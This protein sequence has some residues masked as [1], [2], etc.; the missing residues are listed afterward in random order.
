MSATLFAIPGPGPVRSLPA[1]Y[2][3]PTQELEFT[4]VLRRKP[5]TPQ[6]AAPLD[7]LLGQLPHQRQYLTHAELADATGADA[8]DVATLEAYLQ[9]FGIQ[10][11]NTSL[12]LRQATL[13]GSVQAF[14]Q[15]FATEIAAFQAAGQPQVLALAS[16]LRVP[17]PLHELLYAV[18][19]LSPPVRKEWR[20]TPKPTP[21]P[22]HL[23]KG[24]GAE[25]EAAGSPTSYSVPE[26][27]QAYRFPAE[28]TGAG[29][30]VGIVELGGQFSHEDLAQYFA[31]LGRPQPEII[32]VGTSPNPGTAQLE[33]T[34]DVE[35]VGALLPQ[36][37]L[38]VYYA[39]T[40]AGAL[41][42]IVADE[43]N[44]P[45][46]VSI[47]WA[48][49]EYNYTAQEVQLLNDLCYQAA[50]LGITL[51]AASA[52]LG[53]F[54]GL[55]FPNVSLPSSNPL[56][57][58]CGGTTATLL[59]GALTQEVVW[60]EIFN[61]NPADRMSS[62]GGVSHLYPLPYYQG[63]AVPGYPYSLPQSG[64]RGVPDLAAHASGQPGYQLIYNGQP[65]L[66]GGTSAATPLVAALLALLNEQLGYRL[67]FVNAVLYALAGSAAFRP[68][69]QGNNSFYAAAPYW[70]PCTGLGSP[71]G[72][73]LLALLQQVERTGALAPLAPTPDD[74]A[75][76]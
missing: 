70:N 23:L 34:M 69:T 60:N 48:G 67:G 2:P 31:S 11:K 73:Q 22:P 14:E 39:H 51:V 44:K 19:P 45:T 54:N 20:P 49:S 40:L 9:P 59:N 68:I 32:E 66:S 27:A 10:I 61:N 46:V 13:A 71:V 36:A 38:V 55:A 25:A 42:A 7:A 65:A 74:Q 15:A 29:Q 35:I 41:Q 8:A 50:L 17:A 56:V 21:V 58:G 26:L 63:R 30:V 12:L 52:D 1:G 62:G 47:S 76:T 43:A 3:A 33:V 6:D 16:P 37:K 28:A 57:L 5:H 75:T 4:L 18:Q 53:A 64:A 72:E 24:F